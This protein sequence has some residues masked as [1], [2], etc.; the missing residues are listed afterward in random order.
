MKTTYF[1]NC[2]SIEEAKRLYHKLAVKFHP[3]L[4][5]NLETMQAINAEYDIIAERLKNI[6]ESSTGE[7]YTTEQNSNEIPSDFRDMINN[8][9]HMEGVTVE[10][11]GRWIWLT[12]NTY[13]HKDTIKTLGFKYA[14]NKS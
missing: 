1:S 13:F 2:K 11:V 5:G 9:I 4:G 7:Q 3:D 10:L 8:L 12:G 6:H 14:S